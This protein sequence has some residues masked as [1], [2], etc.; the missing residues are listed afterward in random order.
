MPH[1]GGPSN[2]WRKRTVRAEEAARHAEAKCQE[3]EGRAKTT[4]QAMR[5][6]WHTNASLQLRCD[7]YREEFNKLDAERTALIEQIAELQAH[8][9]VVQRP[10]ESL[11]DVRASITV[12]PLIGPKNGGISPHITVG[13]YPTQPGQAA[14]RV[15][16]LWIKLD[17]SDANE[18]GGGMADAA[19]TML[20]IALQCGAPLELLASKLI[21][22]RGGPG[23]PVWKDYGAGLEADREVSRCLSLLDYLGKWLLVRFCGHTP[24]VPTVE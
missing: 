15:G 7:S 11:P 16:E 12:H 21:G 13:V 1:H 10:R 24:F 14:P 6:A 9:L 17:D 19:A 2:G 3:M 23:G 22:L 20:S 18:L 5:D 4:E 8:P